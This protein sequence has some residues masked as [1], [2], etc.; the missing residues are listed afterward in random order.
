MKKSISKSHITE[1]CQACWLYVS[2]RSFRLPKEILQRL[3]RYLP[4]SFA[5]K[6]DYIKNR[7]Q[8]VRISSVKNILI[9]LFDYFFHLIISV[10]FK[11]PSSSSW[12]S[13]SEDIG[14]GSSALTCVTATK[15][16]V[17]NKASSEFE[18][19]FN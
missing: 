7:S 9:D 19:T 15:R 16:V 5:G 1:R 18:I 12:Y 6:I 4:D 8:S 3:N 2:L 10:I 11:Q 13:G 17:K 14:S